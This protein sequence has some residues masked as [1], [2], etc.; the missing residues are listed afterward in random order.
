MDEYV[1]IW[2]FNC[3]GDS[4]GYGA[5]LQV[6]SE[7]EWRA[8]N[9]SQQILESMLTVQLHFQVTFLF[10]S[11]YT[12]TACLSKSLWVPSRATRLASEVSV[13]MVKWKEDFEF[14]YCLFMLVSLIAVFF[15]LSDS[16]GAQGKGIVVAVIGV[17]EA[18][19]GVFV[20]G[21][22]YTS[23]LWTRLEKIKLPW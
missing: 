18:V 17:I 10:S 11:R 1:Y 9:A 5:F 6:Q 14:L 20:F 2:V 15:S 7:N 22:S 8:G 23:G 4:F 3:L 21:S 19:L 13:F 12:H 16:L